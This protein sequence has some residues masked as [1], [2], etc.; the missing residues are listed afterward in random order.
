MAKI[1]IEKQN[2]FQKSMD[3][4]LKGILR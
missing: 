1:V 3:K 4:V 2:K